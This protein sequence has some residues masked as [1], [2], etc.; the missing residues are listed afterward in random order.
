[1]LTHT[2]AWSLRRSR[3]STFSR[4]TSRYYDV[5]LHVVDEIKLEYAIHI[6]ELLWH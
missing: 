3:M 4:G 6:I 1:M 2:V 5:T